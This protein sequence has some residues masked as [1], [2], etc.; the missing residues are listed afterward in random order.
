[1]ETGSRLPVTVGGGKAVELKG[2]F[3]CG[4]SIMY[5]M[6]SWQD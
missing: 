6:I 5:K 2:E 1:M 4:A 3:R